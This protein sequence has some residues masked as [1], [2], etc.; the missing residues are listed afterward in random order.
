MD[1]KRNISINCIMPYWNFVRKLF[2]WE[3]TTPQ[4]A[5]RPISC[6]AGTIQV[7]TGIFREYWFFSDYGSMVLCSLCLLLN[8]RI[9]CGCNLLAYFPQML[10]FNWR[11]HPWCKREFCCSDSAF[12]FTAHDASS[13]GNNGKGAN[14]ILILRL[15][16]ETRLATPKKT[17][18]YN[19]V[20]W[21]WFG[22]SIKL[23][24]KAENP[25]EFY[26]KLQ[27]ISIKL[28]F[29]N[30][31]DI[32][33]MTNWT[34]ACWS[35]ADPQLFSHDLLTASDMPAAGYIFFCLA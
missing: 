32:I 34:T 9:H 22:L 31:Y 5:K 14:W 27:N 35:T 4:S 30:K 13:V 3:K 7:L 6:S 29:R 26:C 10:F 16:M 21:K 2:S 25:L 17:W 19:W 18:N 15:W 24:F 8:R 20:D 23:H 12:I 1:Q 33:S 28:P 11:N